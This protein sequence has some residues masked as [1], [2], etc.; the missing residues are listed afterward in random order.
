[1]EGRTL[2]V[3]APDGT[4]H[5]YVANERAAVVFARE[6]V[7]ATGGP[8]DVVGVADDGTAINITL[9]LNPADGEVT[10]VDNLAAR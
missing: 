3:T 7:A 4:E 8:V 5:E 6:L 2:K 1:M 9:H 10:G